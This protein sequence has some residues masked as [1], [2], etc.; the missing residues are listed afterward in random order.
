LHHQKIDRESTDVGEWVASQ[1]GK[2]LFEPAIA[3]EHAFREHLPS[4]WACLII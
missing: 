1:C 4:N 3:A 2:P